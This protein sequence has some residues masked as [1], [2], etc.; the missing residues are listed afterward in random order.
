MPIT[1]ISKINNSTFVSLTK[2]GKSIFTADR[3]QYFT[4]L[5]LGNELFVTGNHTYFN[6]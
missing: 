2:T 3:Q 4:F 6:C 5:A 1:Y